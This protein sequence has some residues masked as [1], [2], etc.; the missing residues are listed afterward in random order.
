MNKY[1]KMWREEQNLREQPLTKEICN[2]EYN[3][4]NAQH[5]R[6]NEYTQYL[7]YDG[8]N[9]IADFG[10]YLGLLLGSRDPIQ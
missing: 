5:C 2:T 10:G 9:F 3:V 8:N 6:Y 7:S 1:S 4:E